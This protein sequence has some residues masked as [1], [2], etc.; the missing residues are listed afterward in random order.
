VRYSVV[1]ASP[2]APRRLFDLVADVERYPEFVPWVTTLRTSNRKVDED[3]VITLDAIAEVGFSMVH[4]RFA[5]RVRL[6]APALAIDV[7]LIAGPF[8]RL[9]NQWR[10]TPRASGA[11][12]SFLIDFEFRSRVLDRL[13]KMNFRRAAD[14]LVRCFETRATRLYG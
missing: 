7:G 12:L 8:S 1:R 9:I 5:T 3:G 14:R 6:D 11:D 13:L 4:E 2:Y 10:F